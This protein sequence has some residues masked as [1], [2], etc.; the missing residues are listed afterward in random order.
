MS[1]HTLKAAEVARTF[2]WVDPETGRQFQVVTAW[3]KYVNH[4]AEVKTRKWT[5][6]IDGTIL[7]LG[8]GDTLDATGELGT[9]VDT[10]TKDGVERPVVSHSLHS[11]SITN[12]DTSKRRGGDLLGVDQDDVRKYGHPTYGATDGSAGIETPF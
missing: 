7:E 11:P 1:N 10:W 6:W 5:L 4:K 3:E 8:E 2:I 9:K 12:H